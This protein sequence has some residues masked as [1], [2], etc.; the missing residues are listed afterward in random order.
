MESSL[1]LVD[2][3][4]R[5]Y[6][7]EKRDKLATYLED[8]DKFYQTSFSSKKFTID[9]F[10][11]DRYLQ[12]IHYSW[13]IE[14]LKKLKTDAKL[15]LHLFPEATQKA[16]MKQLEIDTAPSIEDETLEKFLKQELVLT[17]NE[18]LPIPFN[19]LPK[20]LMRMLLTLSKKELISLIDHL[21][22]YDLAF[23]L[24]RVVD[25]KIIKPLYS[26]LDKKET[27]FLKKISK[28][29]ESFSLTK[30]DLNRW[31]KEEKSLRMLMHKRGI[32]R[33]SIA[34]HNE[35]KDLVWHIAHRLDAGRGSLLMRS[36][37]QNVAISIINSIQA[38]IIE[39]VEEENF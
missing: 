33:L 20:S 25:T 35:S 31:D 19:Y 5:K 17:L 8:T 32:L 11:L 22:L 37:D 28:S 9:D 15:F 39:L 34:L 2:A 14:P 3:L 12:E 23:E 26:Y 38:N 27:L 4:I 16:L 6:C 21:S 18:P 1:Y 10:L 13:W 30:M 7:P 36:I 29:A 24:K